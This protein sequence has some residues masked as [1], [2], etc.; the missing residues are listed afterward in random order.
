[1]LH[2][3][4]GEFRTTIL[5]IIILVETILAVL[6]FNWFMQRYVKKSFVYHHHDLT[7]FQ[8]IVT[9][10]IYIAGVAVALVQ[11]PELKI[12]GQSL[13]P[14]AGFISLMA[15][16]ASQ[17]VPRNIKNGILT[18]ILKPF[19]LND[20]IN[21]RGTYKVIVEDINLKSN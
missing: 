9:A 8:H 17:Q 6:I 14:G 11:I 4:F 18:V 16:L 1:M 2:K 5:F 15:G 21:I 7:G 19:R 12:V 20:K 10:I 13:L 3:L